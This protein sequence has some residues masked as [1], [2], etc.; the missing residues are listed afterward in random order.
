MLRTK[1]PRGFKNFDEKWKQCYLETRRYYPLSMLIKADNGQY[2]CT[3]CY[4]FRFY[5]EEMHKAEIDITD[6]L[7]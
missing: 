3:D 2:Y 7:E 1:A 5:K 4:R 6:D